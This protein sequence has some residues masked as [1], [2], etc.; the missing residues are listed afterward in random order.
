MPSQTVAVARRD[1]IPEGKVKVVDVNG[2]R[3][4]LCNYG[5]RIY[6]IDDVCTHDRGPLG[7]GELIGHEIECPRHGARFDVESGRATRLPAVRPVRTYPVHERDGAIE[8]E[9]QT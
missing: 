7:Q 6:A 3:I 9:V 2:V 5:G 4:A 1:E 8:V